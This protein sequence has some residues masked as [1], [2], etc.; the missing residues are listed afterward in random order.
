[1]ADATS[2]FV[3]PVTDDEEAPPEY[4]EDTPEPPID[5]P[6]SPPIVSALCG[7]GM[8]VEVY[9][10]GVE[11][12]GYCVSGSWT[13]RLNRSAQAT[14][15]VPMEMP[16]AGDTNSLLKIVLTDGVD[17]EIVFHGKVMNTETDTDKDGGRTVFNATDAMEEW[18][19]RLVR[20]DDG[21]FSKP[22]GSLET[23]GSDIIA[24]YKTAPRMMQAI[25]YN[26]EFASSGGESAPRNADG[27]LSLTLVGVATGGEELLGAPVDWP[28]SIGDFYAL[29]V[30]TGQLDAVVT[31]TDPGGGVTGE[32]RL[33]NGDY[34]TDR[35]ADVLLQYGTGN[36]SA[37]AI[38]WNRD[39]SNLVNKYWIYGG[40][41]VETAADPP[42]DQHWCF[43]VTG[44]DTFLPYTTDTIPGPGGKAVNDDNSEYITVP[45]YNPLG[46]KIYQSRL[47]YGVRMRVDIFDAYDDN[48][49]PGFGVAGRM[50]Y[51]RLWQIYSWFACEPREII[52]VTPNSDTYIG[53]FRIGDL[54]H[55]EASSEVRGGFSGSQRVYEY[56]VSWEG[57]PS[58]LTLSEIQTSADA[59]GSRDGG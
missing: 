41:R 22:S 48:C 37:A 43:N 55:V 29:L 18:Q 14:V 2:D 33:Y 8:V 57:T 50:M 20:A 25:L 30:S 38:R 31:Y 45:G 27:P 1:M 5:A 52:H 44:Q 59:E 23:D 12:T 32:L 4:P 47:D 51:R 3:G 28:Q 26:S 42:G 35:S 19:W 15:T 40:P 36:H 16:V 21:D 7:T 9:L 46:E 13:P 24:T 53:C 54:I 11:I 39:M 49:I 34:G 6:E 58:N 17:E 56:T 10:D